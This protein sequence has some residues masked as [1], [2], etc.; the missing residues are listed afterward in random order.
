[1]LNKNINNIQLLYEVYP[2]LKKI[3][4]NNDGIIVERALFRILDADEYISS[5]NGTCQG[6]LFVLKGNINVKRINRDGD[7]TNLY[8]ITNGEICHESLI[9]LLENK[10]LNIVGCALQQSIVCVIP[11][12]IV[13]KYLIT[14]SEFLLYMYSDI[15]KKFNIIIKKREDKNHKSLQNRVIR[16]LIEKNSKII[17]ATHKDI[18]YEIDSKREVVSRK[19]KELEKEGQIKLERGKIIILKDLNNLIE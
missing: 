3:D 4:A 11:I 17:Y 13:K 1:M 9:C 8:N 7:E 19:L 14:N 15:C 6:I 12:E 5:S 16:Y 10:T 18:A 2:V